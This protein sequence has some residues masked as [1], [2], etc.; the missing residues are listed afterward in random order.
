MNKQGPLSLWEQCRVLTPG[1]LISRQQV[2]VM[3]HVNFT[4]WLYSNY[5]HP[6]SV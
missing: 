4:A 5:R 3:K 1:S 2:V 6:Y